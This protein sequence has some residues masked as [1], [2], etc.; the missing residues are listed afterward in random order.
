MFAVIFFKKEFIMKLKWNKQNVLR[1]IKERTEKE[2]KTFLPALLNY[3]STKKK[4]KILK[5][6]KL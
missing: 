2:N 1:I 3:A 5:K 4:L 6:C